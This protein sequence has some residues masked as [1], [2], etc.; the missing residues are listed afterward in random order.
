[1]TQ[2]SGLG[3]NEE[4]T[5]ILR[6]SC[7][8]QWGDRV[9][10]HGLVLASTQWYSPCLAQLAQRRTAWSNRRGSY[11]VLRPQLTRVSYVTVH[12]RTQH[13][14]STQMGEKKRFSVC[15]FRL[16]VI[17]TNI[18]RPRFSILSVM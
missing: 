4:E 12:Y 9:S 10:T 7:G 3:S 1:M 16:L 14:S 15:Q 13:I 18:K 2:E 8:F 17:Y 5:I 11:S 6:A